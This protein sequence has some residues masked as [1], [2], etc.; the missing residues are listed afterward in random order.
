MAL[1][2]DVV[3]Y[4]THRYLLHSSN[5]KMMRLLR[6]SVHHTTTASRGISACY[7]SS[8]DFF[9]EIILPYLVPLILVGGGGVDIRFHY[10]VAGLGSMGGVYE[11][12]GYDF[13]VLLQSLGEQSNSM[14]KAKDSKLHVPLSLTWILGGILDNRSHG[15]HHAQANV[16]FADGFGSPGICDTLFGTR[17][18]LS[19]GKRALRDKE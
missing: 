4:L 18:N 1:G 11:H 15:E 19:Q 16:S 9:L 13:G 5:K 8:G 14:D 10:L 17:F 7:M 3:Q 2:H 12:S 6:H